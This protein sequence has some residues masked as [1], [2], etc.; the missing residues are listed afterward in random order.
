MSPWAETE[1]AE[2]RVKSDA[3]RSSLSWEEK[4]ELRSLG[5]AAVR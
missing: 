2:A 4:W 3:E 5:A 1:G